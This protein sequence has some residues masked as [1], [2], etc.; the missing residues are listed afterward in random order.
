MNNIEKAKQ[1]YNKAIDFYKNKDYDNAKLYYEKAIE[2]NPKFSKAYF[3]LASLYDINFKKYNIAKKNYE[4]AIEINPKYSK[5]Y[6]NLAI[7]LKNHF[8]D[9]ENAKENYEKAIEL[10]PNFKE[11]YY[12]LASLL[13]NKL[14]DEKKAMQY[15]AKYT[16]LTKQDDKNYI[17]YASTKIKT[18]NS[19]SIENYFSIKNIKLENLKDKKEIYFLGENGDGKTILL[20]SIF[21]AFQQ[22]YLNNYAHKDLVGK[23]IETLSRNKNLRLIAT[24]SNKK[25]FNYFNISFAENIFAYGVNRNKIKGLKK[26]NYNF[27]TLFSN[28]IELQNPVNWFVKLYN[29]EREKDYR[30]IPLENAIN[31]FKEILEQKVEI[32]VNY[33]KVEFIE[34]GTPIKFHELSDG[35]KSVLIWVADLIMKLSKNQPN[36]KTTKDFEGI[37]LI[38]EIDLHLHPR[39]A[40]SI[41]GKLRKWFPEIQWF[42][43]THS[44]DVIRGAGSKSV[45]YKLY[46]E[47]DDKIN[48]QIV[49]VSEPYSIEEFKNAMS[50]IITTSPLFD[51]PH[52]RMK[53]YENGNLETD[54]D[55]YY[56]KI[57]KQVRADIKLMKKEGKIHISKEEIDM[58]IKNAIEKYS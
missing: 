26:D 58:M 40:Y 34:K 3:S 54:N 23:A 4:K 19:I 9:Y 14:S 42:I 51:L 53:T 16:E 37:V 6:Y 30:L 15:F 21:F 10:N 39:W 29:F 47:F 12:N 8:Q 38:D 17:K 25:E 49:K 18:I 7:L 43:T 55:Y 2:I 1:F 22:H 5:A 36:A 11:A 56:A 20:Q 45:F 57:H 48:K 28:E 27:M 44:P 50:N 33:E 24:D 31:V 46:K 41:V 52:A 32:K 13:K 35:Y